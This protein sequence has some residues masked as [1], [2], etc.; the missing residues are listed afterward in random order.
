MSDLFERAEQVRRDH[1]RGKNFGRYDR[2]V[3]RGKAKPPVI[4]PEKP[5]RYTLT[6]LDC[7]W[8]MWLHRPEPRV[9]L[10]RKCRVHREAKKIERRRSA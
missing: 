10:C 1:E 2:D 3:K 4:E 8:E 6:C 9:P 5:P 7:G